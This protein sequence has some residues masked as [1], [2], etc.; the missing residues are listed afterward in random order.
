MGIAA[1][2]D[3]ALNVA[4]EPVGAAPDFV[5]LR[6]RPF[7]HLAVDVALL[8]PGVD[9]DLLELQHDFGCALSCAHGGPRCFKCVFQEKCG[10]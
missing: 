6:E 5:P 2:R 4:L 10:R 9:F 8:H 7:L 3:P 1:G